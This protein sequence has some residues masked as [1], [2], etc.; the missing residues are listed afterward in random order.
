LHTNGDADLIKMREQYKRGLEKH[1]AGLK[2]K[3]RDK[4]RNEMK[5]AILRIV[6]IYAV[7]GGILPYQLSNIM[8]LDKSNLS[9][10]IDE[11]VEEKKIKRANQQAPF[12]PTDEFNIDP[13]LNAYLFAESF[14]KFLKNR[15][16]IILTNETRTVFVKKDKPY[17]WTDQNDKAAKIDTES[18]ELDFRKYKEFY[19]PKFT[20]YTQTEKNLF[21]FSNRLGAFITM[22]LI[23]AMNQ[24]NYGYITNDFREQNI[25]AQEYINKAISTLVPYLLPTFKGLVEDT[26]M[27]KEFYKEET[28]IFHRW[29]CLEC[30]SII[31]T[32]D[33]RGIDQFILDHQHQTGHTK[34]RM[35]EEE[36]NHSSLSILTK[37]K[38]QPDKFFFDSRIIKR[39]KLGF[40]NVYP[41][42][43]YELDKI[44]EK[45][46]TN[47]ESHKRFT[48]ELYNKWEKQ[49]SC[50]HKFKEPAMTLF[51]YY[52][53]QCS[54][55][56]RI[57]K[58]KP[59]KL[60][61]RKMR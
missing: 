58:V 42:L 46:P 14:S 22:S 28:V 4:K 39:L 55:C 12:F 1:L 59:S 40:N 19:L 52:G 21:E 29:R 61:R 8:Q 27:T 25:I 60:K 50:N 5:G 56:G 38:D 3:H 20:D 48:Q 7:R 15:R 51:G 34:G 30:G 11:L 37:S 57:E 36:Q 26:I 23:L 17:F 10:Y 54:I 45:L 18:Y 2:S 47:R 49:K 16:D 31:E 41:L 9:P 43:G 6:R 35:I 44:I 53:K 24:D 13:L 33:K 32:S